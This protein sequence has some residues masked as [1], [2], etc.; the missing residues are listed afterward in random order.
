ME[1]LKTHE[2]PVHAPEVAAPVVYPLNV[3]IPITLVM[4]ATN[5]EAHEMIVDLATGQVHMYFIADLFDSL[6]SG[7]E[8]VVSINGKT[9]VDVQ[10]F[11][12]E[13]AGAVV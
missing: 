2:V 12:H 8:L 1:E 5:Q 13:Q 7:F 6:D 4:T 3:T 9:R 10:K 11:L